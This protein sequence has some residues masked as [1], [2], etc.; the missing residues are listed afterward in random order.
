MNDQSEN[1]EIIEETVA[2]VTEAPEATAPAEPEGHKNALGVDLPPEGTMVMCDDGVE[3]PVV[4]RETAIKEG[5]NRYFT[6]LACQNGHMCE[7][8][9]KGYL[10][11]TCGR[12]RQKDR[13]KSKL[14]TDPEFK[15]KQKSKR[16]E[17]L[18]R[19]Y[20]EDPD[21]KSKQLAKAKERRAKK[22]E[23]RKAEN[24]RL[25]AEA[26]AKGETAGSATA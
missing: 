24:I 1:T 9:V 12:N 19:K 20:Q 4:Y 15:A 11:T 10:C 13:I 6:G 17:R 23:I 14:A 2:P 25:K 18:K 22:A 5:V 16:A 21:Y 3:R 26:E 7:R 8:K